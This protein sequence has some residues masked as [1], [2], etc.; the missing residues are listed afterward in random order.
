MTARKV[1]LKPIGVIRT[2]FRQAAGTPIQSSRAG[3]AT[4]TVEVFPEFAPGLKDLDG[5]ERIWLIYWFDRAPEPRL[6]VTPFLDDRERGVFATRAPARPNPIG[7]SPVRLIRIAG[8]TLEVAGVDILDETP[9]L[10]IKP[11]VPEF[12]SHAVERSGWFGRAQER[13]SVADARFDG[14]RRKDTES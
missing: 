5:F 11:Y 6:S 2:G 12:D 3:D 10:D 14:K 13:R 9:L 1:H 4:G 8:N 7:M